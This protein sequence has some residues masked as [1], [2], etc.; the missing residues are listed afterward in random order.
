MRV[1][2]RYIQTVLCIAII[3][4]AHGSL[5][6]GKRWNYGVDSEFIQAIKSPSTNDIY[7]L[8]YLGNGDSVMSR[9]DGSTGVA[10]WAKRITLKASFKS[11]ALNHDESKL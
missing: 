3:W 2:K 11:L 6:T 8:E 1:F 10:T 7:T 9:I 5:K 4:M